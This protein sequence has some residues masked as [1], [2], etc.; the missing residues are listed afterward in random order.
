MVKALAYLACLIVLVSGLHVKISHETVFDAAVVSL[1]SDA[2]TYLTRCTN[3]GPSGSYPDSAS[4][5]ETSSTGPAS[6]WTIEAVG[7]QVALKA[8][9][10]RYLARCNNCWNG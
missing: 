9:T 1:K 7:N 5:S 6:Q 10:G 3:C 4:L 8:D 2:G